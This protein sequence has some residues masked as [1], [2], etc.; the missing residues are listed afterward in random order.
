MNKNFDCIEMKRNVQD[1]IWKEAGETVEGLFKYIKEKRKSNEML[2]FLLERENAIY[3][4][5]DEPIFVAE[6]KE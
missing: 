3:K 1:K 4:F 6:P 2:K 5:V